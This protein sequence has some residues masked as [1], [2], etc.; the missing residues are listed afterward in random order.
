MLFGNALLVALEKN[1]EWVVQLLLEKGA[2]VNAEGQTGYKV[3]SV[4]SAEGCERV[5]QLLQEKGAD[6]N[7]QGGCVLWKALTNGYVA[8]VRLLLKHKADVSLIFHD[9]DGKALQGIAVDDHKAV[10]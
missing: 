4:A 5:A 10:I 6:L 3:L 9:D 8:L 2:D 7:A 1:Y